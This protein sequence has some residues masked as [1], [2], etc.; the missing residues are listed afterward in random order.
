M[1]FLTGVMTAL[2]LKLLTRA[3]SSSSSHQNRKSKTKLGLP[4]Y[5]NVLVKKIVVEN[6]VVDL[7]G[8]EMTRIIWTMIKDKVNYV[9]L[10][11]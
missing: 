7:D 9:C 2:M 8:D 11:S 6:P 3:L 1:R 10:L 5:C 4:D